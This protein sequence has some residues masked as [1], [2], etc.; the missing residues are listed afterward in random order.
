MNS[1]FSWEKCVVAITPW[2]VAMLLLLPL[3]SDAHEINTSYSALTLKAD[4]IRVVL[5][6]DE[7]DLLRLDPQIDA[8]GD[9]VLWRG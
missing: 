8:N 2:W 6:I 4:E 3:A 7:A 5:S 9:G 1:V